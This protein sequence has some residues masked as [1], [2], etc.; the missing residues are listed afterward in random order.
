M[1]DSTTER[2]SPEDRLILRKWLASP[3]TDKESDGM[4]TSAGWIEVLLD[5][6][7]AS[8]AALDRVERLADTLA[9]FGDDLPSAKAAARDI[10]AA[11][12]DE[13]DQRSWDAEVKQ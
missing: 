2:V 3:F 5:A 1:T 4:R 7:E 8:E 12:A 11:I 13:L 10:R 6:L 9:Y